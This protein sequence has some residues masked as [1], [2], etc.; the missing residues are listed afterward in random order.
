MASLIVV[1][2]ASCNDQ[3]VAQQRTAPPKAEIGAQTLAPQTVTLTAELPGRTSA[4]LVS[5]VR[6]RVGGIVQSRNFQEGRDVAAGDVLYELDPAP[7][8]AAYNN[9]EAALRRAEGAVPS[10]RSRFLR[11]QSLTARNAISQQ[12]L[13]EAQTA[14]VQ[15][16]SDV[17]AARSALQTARINLEYTKIRAPIGGRI[18][19]S[20]VT[21]GA[22]VTAD[23]I[24]PLA[25]IRQ[26]DV[27]NVD[28][29]QSS[30]NLLRLKRALAANQIKSNGE[31]VT[32]ELVLED[33]SRYPYPG[34]LQ[35]SESSV[36]TT[37]GTVTIR[38]SFPNPHSLLMPGM[39]VRAIVE[40]GSVESRFLVPQRA[41]SRNPRGE[42]IA[43]FVDANNKV[44]ERRV[45]VDRSVGNSWL[46]SGGVSNGDR[47]LVDGLQRAL[48]GQE[49]QVT[50]VN[51]NNDTGEVEL[52][53]IDRTGP[54]Q[55]SRAPSATD[56]TRTATR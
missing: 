54:D 30:S 1:S 45:T 21:P 46:V 41:V 8:E 11:N 32:V 19:A 43:K 38:A 55:A 51:V 3:P 34:K 25:T 35:F 23:Q 7:F 52:V 18:D 50:A 31:F 27:I 37:A 53:E 10:A 17:V 47:I 16:E 2:L 5:E 26:L 36:S 4:H 6:P 13:D 20:S 48:N 42:A 9:A 40:E 49:V 56:I 28:V 44:E 39:Y 29:V 14:L 22:L 33:G 15:A 12:D 24:S